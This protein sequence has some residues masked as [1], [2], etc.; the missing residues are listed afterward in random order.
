MLYFPRPVI[1]DYNCSG[2][3]VNILVKLIL[4]PTLHLQMLYRQL[5]DQWNCFSLNIEFWHKESFNKGLCLDCAISWSDNFFIHFTFK[6]RPYKEQAKLW[7]LR[8]DCK[9]QQSGYRVL[10]V[11][12]HHLDQLMNDPFFGMRR[13]RRHRRRMPFFEICFLLKQLKLDWIPE[14]WLLWKVLSFA[15]WQAHYSLF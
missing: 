7:E 11:P 14:N 10:T 9:V 13:R 4:R 5:L 6:L 8:K 12:N 2:Y 3:T 15:F 1:K